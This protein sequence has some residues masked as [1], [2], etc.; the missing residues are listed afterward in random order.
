MERREARPPQA[1]KSRFAAAALPSHKTSSERGRSGGRSRLREARAPEIHPRSDKLHGTTIHFVTDDLDGGPIIAQAS[2]HI[3]PGDTP[4]TL[5]TRVQEL[6]HHLYPMVVQWFAQG[7]V[8][9]HG[10]Q[11]SLDGKLLPDHGLLVNV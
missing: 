2:L 5:K 11:V 1:F 8:E 7:R 3:L 4:E 6:E 10:D 9:L